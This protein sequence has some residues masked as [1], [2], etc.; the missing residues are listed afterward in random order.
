MTDTDAPKYEQTYRAVLARLKSGRYPVGGRLPTEKELAEQFAVSRVTVRRALEMLVQD[1]YVE[2]RQGSGYT[3]LTLSPASDT[4]LT[5]FT[6]AMLRAGHEPT[7]RLLEI[8]EVAAGDPARDT[9]PA[10]MQAEAL[11]RISRLRLVDGRPRMLVE[12][13]APSALVAGARPED[14]PESGPG[15]SILRILT[16][17]FRLSWSAAC[18][19]IRPLLPP[20]EIG[21][22]LGVAAGAPILCQS[23][24]A[25]DEAGHA[26][27]HENVFRDGPVSFN[28]T[29]QARVPRH[30]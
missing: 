21:A 3:V 5:S 29:R 18:E 9:L 2:S 12:T 15:Q 4:C 28:L 25:Y 27:F 7:S 23:C 17:R 13:Y 20:P 10:E 30:G 22:R 16:N 26:V 24:T 11:T 8:G 1:G 6:D 19:D 14:F